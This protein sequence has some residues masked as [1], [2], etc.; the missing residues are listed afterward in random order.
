MARR[1]ISITDHKKRDA[2]IEVESP[3]GGSSYNY[4]NPDG[5][6]VSSERFIKS[7]E[8]N[9]Y[10]ALLEE[11]G[12]PEAVAEA[13]IAGDPEVDFDTVGRRVADA[14]RVWLQPDGS[15]LHCARQLL[16]RYDPDGQEIER[17]ELVDVEATVDEEEPLAWTGRLFPVE[18]VVRRFVLVRQLR[19]RHV[20][21][22]T[23]DFLYEMA[24]HL[25]ETDKMLL[26]GTSD[27]KPLIFRTNGSPYRGFLE[28]RTDGDGYLLVLHLSNLELKSITDDD[29]E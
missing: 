27:N 10:E 28:G 9:S 22:L 1:T 14:D 11:H 19:L 16:V 17:D 20:N 26:V 6:V 3:G 23:F 2:Q 12:D 5:V 21:G 29:E 4:V 8:Q 25:E 13:L 24:E 7:T 15:I 18:Q